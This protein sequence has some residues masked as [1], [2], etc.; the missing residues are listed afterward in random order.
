MSRAVMQMALDALEDVNNE[1]FPTMW[2]GAFNREV[3]AL[4]AEL[5]KLEPKPI[6]WM[7]DPVKGV[8][9][10]AL[11]RTLVFDTPISES[12]LTVTLILRKEDV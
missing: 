2:F 3:E 1:N 8:A 6:G 10:L 9:P 5:A 11:G 7:F 4:K 12:D